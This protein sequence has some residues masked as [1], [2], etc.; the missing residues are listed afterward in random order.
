MTLE[1]TEVFLV[2]SVR[3][4]NNFIE[5][6]A[7]KRLEEDGILAYDLETTGL[8]PRLPESKI[9]LAQLGDEQMGW[10]IP[11]EGW[12]GVFLEAMEL[13]EG[14]IV[15]HNTT[16]D[17]RWLMLH[18]GWSPPYERIHDTMIMA[19]IM[20]PHL[21]A[22]LKDLSNRHVDRRASVGEKLL[23]Q[24]FKEQGW[25]WDTV[26]VDFPIYW[27]YGAIDPIITSHLFRHYRA[28]VKYPKSYELEMAARRIV[29]Q[30]EDN[31]IR[32]D[33]E[34][35]AEQYEKLKQYVKDSKEWAE[36]NWGVNINSSAQLIPFF[37]NTLG[38]EFTKFTS[39]G[40]PSASAEQLELFAETGDESVKG[41][42][43][44]ILDVKKADKKA[45]T[46]F[47]NFL[48]FHHESVLHASFKTLQARTGRMSSTAPALQ[49][50]SKSDPVLRDA[51]IPHIGEVLLSCDYSQ[52]ELRLMCHYSGDKNLQEA[53]RI[54]DETGGDFFVELGKAIYND[55]EF[56]KKD[57]RRNLI[58]TFMYAFLYGAGL[59]KMAKSANV[60]VGEMSEFIN[61]L[62]ETYP[63]I[64]E[65]KNKVI[66][67]GEKRER[68]EGQGYVVTPSGR[69]IP[70]D[71][72][73]A[74]VLVNYLLQGTAAEILKEA[75]VRLD[76]AGLTKYLL[77]PIHDEVV[78]S[79]PVEDY[80][81]IA[82][83][84]SEIMSVK[85]VYAV[86]L[87]ADAEGPYQRWGD[88]VRG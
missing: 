54:A 77:L 20:E 51:F 75:L 8:N 17:N 33:L 65:F 56:S 82:R 87:I 46:Y 32:I 71:R 10:A 63:G 64:D 47:K 36:E 57:V 24:A 18:A 61:K 6:V 23:K 55:P 38:L 86:D 81:W 74:R 2:N 52:V 76:A 68:E 84:I 88:K 45:N 12:S 35:C 62:N 40:A 53:F 29:S 15:G 13:W 66:A 44:F 39:K 78:A 21:N 22:S 67:Q 25:D 79:V 58:K 70:C 16:F 69:R 73:E 85:G 27:N 50:I 83:D 4:A 19:Q 5:W 37:Q 26:P 48:E 7:E 1:G 31:G 60:T 9:R 3:A 11:W 14:P 72:G 34:Y 59:D 42:V 41:I 49:T 80:E 28:D 43:D 30:M